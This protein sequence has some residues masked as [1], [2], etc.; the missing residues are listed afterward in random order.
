MLVPEA[1]CTPDQAAGYIQV[2]AVG[3]MQDQAAGYIQVQAVDFIQVQAVGFTQ[4]LVVDFIQALAV[5]CT[6]DPATILIEA[7]YHLGLYLLNILRH[8]ICKI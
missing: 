8:M 6:P 7:T 3:Y 1:V 4:G 2:Q 5:E